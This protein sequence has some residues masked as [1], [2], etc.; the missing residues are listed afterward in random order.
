MHAAAA[1]F[2]SELIP[3]E[4]SGPADYPAAF[5]S[6][7]ESSV[8]AVVILASAHFFPDTEVLAELARSARLPTACEWPEMAERG[9]LIG[10]GPDRPRLYRRVADYVARLFRGA[11]P[12]ALPI[13]QPTNLELAINLKT[14]KALGLTVPE[15]LLVG[16]DVVIE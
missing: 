14:A 6:M 9:C 10:Y 4:V 8:Q 7:R 16:A 3:F 1:G 15:P 5:A 12:D 11:R 13:E 2:G